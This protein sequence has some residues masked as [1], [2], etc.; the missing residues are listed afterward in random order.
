[1]WR[2]HFF[3]AFIVIPFVLWQS[4]TGALYLWSE[5]LMDAIHPE[6]RFVVARGST[7]PAS[8]QVRAA[9]A[10]QVAA[11]W[12][13]GME[14]ARATSST[15]HHGVSDGPGVQRILISEDPRRSTAVMLLG[16]NG[17]PHPVFV[18]PYTG[19]V[20]GSLSSTAWLPG[21]T[22]ALHGGWPLGDPG[23]WLLELGDGWAIVMIATGLYL[24]W[25]RGRGFVAGLWPRLNS[26]MRVLIRDLHSCVA[27]WFSVVLLFFL[28]SALPWTAFWGGQILTRIE[29]ATDQSDP[30]G[31]SPGGASVAQLTRALPSLDQVVQSARARDVRGTLDVR[32]APWPDAPLFMTNVH[33]PPSQDRTILGSASSGAL[34]G[35]YTSADLPAI[36][37]FVALGVH[38]HQGDFGL[39]N[40]WI[41]TA[42]AL[43]L[44]WLS[45]TGVIS[46]WTRR[47]SHKLAPPPRATGR[48]PPFLVPT[49]IALG[50]AFPILG[51]SV[52]CILVA[53]FTFG[54]LMG[55]PAANRAQA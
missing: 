37:R 34:I 5:R 7:M 1:L 36:P 49:G 12:H 55:T 54:R 25:P 19:Q 23:S 22:R 16:P 33:I 20:L 41:N 3:A 45:V 26:G 10:S 38:V 32:L 50:V 14:E 8:A 44:V 13:A 11:S 28:I 30:A 18:D 6:L 24:W 21:L 2:W 35:D 27:V 46:W 15:S 53:D 48:A 39:P 17:L 4:T 40:L 51:L 31:F 9:L 52:A 47:P 43:A 29:A 42:F